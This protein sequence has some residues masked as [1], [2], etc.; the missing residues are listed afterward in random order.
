MDMNKLKVVDFVASGIRP[1]DTTTSGSSTTQRTDLKPSS[2]NSPTAR[3]SPSTARRLVAKV[4][5]PGRLVATVV[6]DRI[7][8]EQ[9]GVIR[10]VINR[11]SS[12]EVYVPYRR[13]FRAA[14]ISGYGR[15]RAVIP[16]R[17]LC[18]TNKKPAVVCACTGDKAR[19]DLQGFGV[20]ITGATGLEPATS[21]VT[22]RR[23]NQLNYAPVVAEV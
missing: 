1:V 22:G 2:S 3:A 11:M 19:S 21:G 12:S 9:T 23:S 18:G 4:A 16:V 7:G 17:D 15:L 10:S 8:Y 14:G 20:R 5:F 6:L 13:Y